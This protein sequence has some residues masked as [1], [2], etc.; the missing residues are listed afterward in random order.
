MHHP[1]LKSP[2]TYIYI[3]CIYTVPG[4]LSKTRNWM[5]SQARRNGSAMSGTRPSPE[6]HNKNARCH[7][8]SC[9]TMNF[10]FFHSPATA[11]RANVAAP[12]EAADMPGVL[13]NAGVFCHWLSEG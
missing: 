6:M 2:R 3:L 13:F 8:Y 1:L 11:M 5:L 10:P 4:M 12:D 7:S 9:N